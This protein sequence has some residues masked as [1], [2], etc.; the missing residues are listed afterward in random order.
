MS[1]SNEVTY[2]NLPTINRNAI[3]I[4]P[5]AAFWEWAQDFPDEDLELT[6]DE[7]RKDN[8]TYLIPEQEAEPDAW[9]KRNF[10]IIFDHELYGW[11]TN[12]SLWPKDRSFKAFKKFFIV[13]FS[14]VVIDLGKGSIYK[15]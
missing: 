13:H 1:P 15:D 5:T 3:F 14:S 12:P 9:I 6:L 4:E 8:T 7:L 2:E 11:C 10:T